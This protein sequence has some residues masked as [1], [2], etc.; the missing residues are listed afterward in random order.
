MDYNQIRLFAYNLKRKMLIEIGF[1]GNILTTYRFN[2]LNE[3]KEIIR[4]V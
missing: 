2:D 4:K 1:R 3:L